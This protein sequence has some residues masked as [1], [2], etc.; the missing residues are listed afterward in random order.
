MLHNQVWQSLQKTLD[1]GFS[2]RSQILTVNL[3]NKLTQLWKRL[4]KILLI[5]T[6]IK[7]NLKKRKINHSTHDQ[8]L[9][10]YTFI[11]KRH[12][13]TIRNFRLWLMCTITMISITTI[14]KIGYLTMIQKLI[15]WYQSHHMHRD[16]RVL[17]SSHCW[18]S[19]YYID[20]N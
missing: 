11:I 12:H 9:N 16:I 6:K 3:L 8:L 13:Y 4:S 20:F 5:K 15:R 18:Q 2:E 10:L 14:G 19:I 7:I 1:R 17:S